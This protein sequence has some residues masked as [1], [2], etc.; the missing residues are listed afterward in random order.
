MSIDS[1]IQSNLLPQPEIADGQSILGKDDFLKLMLTQLQ[2][3]DPLDPMDNQEMVA[4]M[5]QFSSLEQMSNLNESFENSAANTLFMDSTRLLGKNIHILDPGAD[6]S[7]GELMIS[8]VQSV[9]FSENGPVLSLENG[10]LTT[11]DQIVKV[12][13]PEAVE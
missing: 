2:Q 1:I 4:Q 7:S 8:K 12:E 3:Q 10:T 13:E 6:P 9:S 5:A 11:L